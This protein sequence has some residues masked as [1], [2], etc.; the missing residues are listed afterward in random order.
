MVELI[1]SYFG[2]LQAPGLGKIKWPYLR[3]H[4]THTDNIFYSTK[5]QVRG[6]CV[7]GDMVILFSQT[8]RFLHKLHILT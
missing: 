2:S 4:K 6:L 1:N 3:L 8:R 7:S 5:S